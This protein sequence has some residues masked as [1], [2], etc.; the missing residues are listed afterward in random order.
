MKNKE[1][2]LLV[3]FVIPLYNT[4]EY[5]EAC[6]L[7]VLNSSLDKKQYEVIVIND[8]STDGGEKIVESLIKQH[9]N[10]YLINK[11]NGGQST[12][13]NIGLSK[14]K[15][16]YIFFL[17]SDDQIISKNLN[18]VLLY[19]DANNLDMF[20]IDMIY[21]TE[22]GETHSKNRKDYLPVFEE[23][24]SGAV[25]M[26][27]FTV[28][29][30]M[31][32]YLY[33]NSIIK[34]NKLKMIEGVYHEDEDFVMRYLLHVKRIAYKKYLLYRQT[35]R[36][37]ST[38]RNKDKKHRER[39]LMDLLEVVKSL[40]KERKNYSN[41]SLEYRGLTKKIEQLTISFFL[42]GFRDKLSFLSMKS[43]EDEL[44]IIGLYPI[45]IKENSLK[46]KVLAYLLNNNTIKRKLFN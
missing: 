46:F 31:W 20:P 44:K 17:D 6:I 19:A 24:I 10:V 23:P 39:L 43:I 35:L 36:L 34:E 4:K 2:K 22:E 16:K 11:E 32:R 42:R 15:G 18:K 13:R 41:S 45:Q 1:E 37:N 21:V 3:S 30:T 25:F 7:S 26:N 5:I 14:A 28:E 9:A 33:K 40:L 8:G 12:A 27:K 38:V 29:G